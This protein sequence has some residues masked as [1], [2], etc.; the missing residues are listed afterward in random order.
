MIST[1]AGTAS[2]MSGI[3][4][5]AKALGLKKFHVVGIQETVGTAD[6]GLQALSGAI[7]RSVG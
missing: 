2:M 3:A 5:G 4:A 1:L 6:I 7:D